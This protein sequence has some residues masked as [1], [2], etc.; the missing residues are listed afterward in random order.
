[1]NR[2][3]AMQ[4]VESALAAA[5]WENATPSERVD[6]LVEIATGLQIRPRSVD[7]LFGALR[8]YDRAQELCPPDAVLLAARIAAKRATALQALPGATPERLEEALVAFEEALKVLDSQGTA[9]EVAE[10]EMNVGLAKHTLAACG[11]GRLSE[12]IAHYHRALRTFTRERY[13]AE[14]AT[15][16]NNLATAYLAIPASDQSGRLREALAVQSFEAAL[17][18]VTLEDHPNEY[19][20]L[21]NNLGNALQNSTSGHPVQNRL[22]AVESYEQALKVRKASNQPGAYANTVA[23]LALCLS[24]LPDDVEQPERGNTANLARARQLYL[25][26]L[27]IFQ[28]QGESGKVAALEGALQEVSA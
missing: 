12:S 6:M 9:E 2:S 15:L 26:A 20:M 11:R 1:M 8:L 27:S 3:M 13:P 17:Q 28:A 14:Y 7:D 4:Q 22:R 19:A 10:L 23:N 16:H 25:E 5:D 18:I 21:Q 24:N